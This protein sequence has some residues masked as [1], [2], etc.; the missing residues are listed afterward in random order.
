MKKSITLIRHAKSAWNQP[1][2]SDFDRPLNKRGKSD[3]PLMGEILKKR[4]IKFDL[5]LSSPA[6]RA[7]TTA[8]AICHATGYTEGRIEQNRDLYLAS[9]AE[10]IEIVHSVDES[11]NR[12]AV[13]GHNPGLT[14]LG[15]VLSDLRID[16]MPTCSIAIFEA[17]IDSWKSLK[18]A[19]CRTID[20]LF[21]KRFK[22]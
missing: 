20:F 13:I 8:R 3:S 5:V 9:A 7:I 18:P 22:T 21:P 12:I 4:N 6:E 10:I 14:V 17:D 16:N 15:N 19:S 1:N 2:L 11:F